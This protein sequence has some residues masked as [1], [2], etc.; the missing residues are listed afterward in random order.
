MR[1]ISKYCF[2]LLLC[3]LSVVPTYSQEEQDIEKPRV[4]GLRFGVDLSRFTLYYFEP[5]RTA[6]EFSV[7][8][9]TVRNLYPVVEFGLQD[10]QMEKPI[11]TY[12]SEGY[13]FRFGI[14][15]NFQKKQSIDQYEMVFAGFRYS[16]SKLSHSADNILIIDDYWGDYYA[17][18]V[19]E[20]T[21][22]AH[23]FEITSGIRAELFRNFFIGWSFRVRILLAQTKDHVMEP[24]YIP[25]FGRGNKRAG[26]GFNYSIY[27]RIPLI[28]TIPKVRQEN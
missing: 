11:Y 16:F 2:S 13:Y 22:Y 1:R 18:A 27:Y 19:P 21:S 12:Q 28:K 8:F 17:P 15:Y 7:D 24:Y 5:E 3:F 10:I 26:I 23:W 6:Y 20:N 9:E 25:G 14:D 4:R